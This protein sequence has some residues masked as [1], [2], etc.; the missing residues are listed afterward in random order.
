M[1][2]QNKLFHKK[3]SHIEK[4]LKTGEINEKQAELEFFKYMFN[5]YEL[6]L[7]Q[8]SIINNEL[9]HAKAERRDIDSNILYFANDTEL[10][11]NYLIKEQEEFHRIAKEIK[12]NN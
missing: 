6:D 4:R 9:E 12:A 10:I 8:H 2:E 5:V 11:K 3:M 7:Q 1:E